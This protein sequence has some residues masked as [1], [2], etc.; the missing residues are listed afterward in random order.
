LP[1]SVAKNRV[2]SG[3]GAEGIPL[4]V[5]KMMRVSKSESHT[6]THPPRSGSRNGFRGRLECGAGSGRKIFDFPL[7]AT[8]LADSHL[9]WPIRSDFARMRLRSRRIHPISTCE[10][11]NPALHL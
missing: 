3:R 7:R 5:S 8:S 11:V 2:A 10:R 6:A 9:F 1:D 4:F